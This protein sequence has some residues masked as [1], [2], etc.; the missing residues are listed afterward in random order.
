MSYFIQQGNKL[1]V[2][3]DAALEVHRKLPV[4]NYT[5]KVDAFGGFFL[6]MIDQHES[7]GKIYGSTT[8]WATRILNTFDSRPSGTGVL[9]S[10][11][12]GSGKTLLA[13]TISRMGAELG[14]PTLTISQPLCGEVFNKFIQD[15]DI[16]CIVLFDEF[17]KVYDEDAQKQLLT[18]LDGMYPTKKLFVMTCNDIWRI[19]RHMNNRPGRIFYSLEFKGIENE[20]IEEYC[21]DN[22]KNQSH[23]ESVC[24]VATLFSAF[25]FDMLKAL[26][27]EMNRYD[28]SAQDAM[29][30][31]NAK[32]TA[33]ENARYTVAI[34][35]KGRVLAENEYQPQTWNGNPVSNDFKVVLLNQKAKA[36]AASQK[37]KAVARLRSVRGDNDDD[38]YY[39]EDLI[40]HKNDPRQIVQVS[41]A[42]HLVSV[43]PKAGT[44]VYNVEDCVITLTKYRYADDDFYTRVF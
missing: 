4:G 26:V 11:E 27:E 22:L 7:V 38:E 40:R 19:D 24:R 10:G 39:P 29:K 21:K 15:I 9:L 12:K 6:E 41:P 43:D 16:P 18:L 25:N 32:P 13:K 35:F 23:I 34:E 30:L 28:E 42:N 31:L 8:K 14:I 5:I 33:S 37:L 3:D 20:F 44:F 36:E 1:S 2:S 17:E